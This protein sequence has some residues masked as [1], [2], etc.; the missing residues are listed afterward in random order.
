MDKRV[1][2]THAR[3]HIHTMQ[4]Y[5]SIVKN[6]IT[7]FAAK[8]MDME[9]NKPSKV[10]KRQI[11]YNTTYHMESKKENKLANIIKNIQTYISQI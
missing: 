1:I 11:L 7:Q 10:T 6:K 4:Y 8:W 2:D 9:G 5:P 3:T